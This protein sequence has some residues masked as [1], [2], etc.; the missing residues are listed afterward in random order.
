MRKIKHISLALTITP[1]LFMGCT[2]EKVSRIIPS[3]ST[4]N[5]T[6]TILSQ[7]E[8]SLK[9]KD[10]SKQIISESELDKLV[11]LVQKKLALE[12]IQQKEASI[13]TEPTKLSP[14]DSLPIIPEEEL[15]YADNI[16][17]DELT[18]LVS[19]ELDTEINGIEGIYSI[20]IVLNEEIIEKVEKVEKVEEI[21]KESEI[22]STAIAFLDIPYIWAANGPTSFDCSGFTKYVF[23]EH[24]LTIPRYSGHQAKVGTKVTYAELKVGDLV[25]FDTDKKYKKKVNHVGIYI[26]DNK[27]IHASS[28]KKK[29]V[30]TSFKKKRF[31]KKRFLWGQRI[32]KDDVIYASL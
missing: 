16:E 10:S 20:P 21:S 15:L 28:A 14:I 2:Q 17:L 4:D 23:K 3:K 31:Y 25:F 26:G 19:S 12:A 7:T 24:G 13:K 22:I 18:K 5:H 30:I 6:Q 8:R 32:I 1:L 9:A 29:V 11:S 27:F